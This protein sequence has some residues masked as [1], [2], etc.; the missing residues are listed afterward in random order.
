MT[1]NFSDFLSVEQKRSLLEQ[2]IV[3]FAAEGYQHTI[4]K[5]VAIAAGKLQEA[6][7]ADEQINIIKTA[8]ETYQSELAILEV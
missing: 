7:Y 8:I 6:E 4:N 1:M 5:Q 2:K 3:Q